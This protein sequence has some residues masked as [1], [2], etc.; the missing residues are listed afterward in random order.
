MQRRIWALIDLAVLIIFFELVIAKPSLWWLLIFL[1]LIHF[2]VETLSRQLSLLNLSGRFVSLT[3]I[4]MLSGVL[5]FVQGELPRHLIVVAGSLFLFGG[6]LVPIHPD[7]KQTI[8]L[9]YQQISQVVAVLLSAAFVYSSSV[10]LRFSWFFGSLV[11][12]ILLILII[13][14]Q[15]SSWREAARQNWLAIL[16]SAEFFIT[17]FILPINIVSRALVVALFWQLTFALLHP[18]PAVFPRHTLAREAVVSIS[19]IFIVLVFSQWI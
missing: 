3:V 17:V 18:E 6:V 13:I 15:Y 2:V 19:L 5:F 4:V 14:D 7:G 10:F 9:V 11:F 16:L 12:V 1:W 8:A